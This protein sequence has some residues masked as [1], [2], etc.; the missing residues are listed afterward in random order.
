MRSADP[1]VAYRIIVGIGPSWSLLDHHD[2]LAAVTMWVCGRS[3]SDGEEQWAAAVARLCFVQA[4]NRGSPIHT[5]ADEARAVAE[6]VH[7]DVSPQFLDAA[8]A[9]GETGRTVADDMAAAT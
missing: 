1:S 9:G 3:P 8:A 5:L 6:V 7:D 4:Q 2:V